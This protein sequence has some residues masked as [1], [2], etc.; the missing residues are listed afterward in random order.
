M[1]YLEK[2]DFL[3]ISTAIYLVVVNVKTTR[4]NNSLF[5]MVISCISPSEVMHP[6]SVNLI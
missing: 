1:N 2:S 4:E 6:W 5:C 3:R